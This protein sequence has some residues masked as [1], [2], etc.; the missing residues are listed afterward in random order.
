MKFDSY[1]ICRDKIYQQLLDEILKH[2]RNRTANCQCAGVSFP[3]YIL[4]NSKKLQYVYEK[5]EKIKRS[6]RSD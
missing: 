6:I 2:K 5:K 1:V 4:A 3:N